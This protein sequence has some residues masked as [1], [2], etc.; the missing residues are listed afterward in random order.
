MSNLTANEVFRLARYA[1]NT[2]APLFAEV[3]TIEPSLQFSIDLT[4]A[5]Q[6]SRFQKDNHIQI[7]AHWNR[8]GMF[9]SSGHLHTQQD[10][11][12]LAV[13]IRTGLDAMKSEFLTIPE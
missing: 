2:L 4:F 13:R 1:Y 8:G 9:L 11:D 3:K 12:T 10:V 5:D 6:D 7:D